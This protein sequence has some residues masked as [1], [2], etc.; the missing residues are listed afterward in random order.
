MTSVSERGDGKVVATPD[1]E[2]E[3]DLVGVVR[4]RAP[5]GGRIGELVRIQPQ[6]DGT[7]GIA[8]RLLD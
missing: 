6:G 1:G 2:I 5:D 7:A 3:A 4:V 8:V